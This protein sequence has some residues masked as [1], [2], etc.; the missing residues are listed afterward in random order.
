MKTTFICHIILIMLITPIFAQKNIVFLVGERFHSTSQTMPALAISLEEQ[1]KHKTYYI[2]IPKNGPAENIQLIEKADLLVCYLHLRNL[3]KEQLSLINKYLDS[4]KPLIAFNSTS[5]AF[6]SQPEWFA[7]NFGGA[8][9]GKVK[10]SNQST[11]TVIPE[12][13]KHPICRD[14]PSLKFKTTSP[15]TIPGPLSIGATPLLMGKSGISPAFPVAW[16]FIPKKGN[17]IFYTSLGTAE[18][19]K[20]PSFTKLIQ[21]AV[22]WT[23]SDHK[24]S[25]TTFTTYPPPPKMEPPEKAIILFDG[26]D[27]SQ[28]RHWDLLQHPNSIKIDEQIQKFSNIDLKTKPKW[29]VRNNSIV[30]E[31]GKG[32]LISKKAFGNYLLNVDFLMPEE[33]DYIED[34]TRGSGGVFISGRYEIRIN[35][36]NYRSHTGPNSIYSLRSADFESEM[37][38]GIWHNMKIRYIHLDKGPAL[39]SVDIN[40]KRM[41]GNIR[42]QKT[43]PYG[44]LEPISRENANDLSLHT[45]DKAF[46]DEKM[47]MGENEYT[48]ATRFKTT[49]QTGTVFARTSEVTGWE[50]DGKAFFIGNGTL[51]YDIGWKGIISTN[52]Q[53]SDGKWHHVVLTNTKDMCIMY[54]DGEVAFMKKKFNSPDPDGHVFKIG[55]GFKNFYRSFGGEISNVRY[56][57]KALS[58]QE[59]M[60]LSERNTA[61]IKPIFDWKPEKKVN[62]NVESNEKNIILK[63]PIRL[64]GDFSRIRYANIWLKE[65]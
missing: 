56:F 53:V 35:T 26:K 42:L 63:G 14:L 39:V 45:V 2:N 46:T 19:F 52:R 62:V 58:Y 34:D 20:K 41:H 31:L 60:Q 9:R 28:W 57:N 4:G 23:L 29:S 11:V 44:I 33:P 16:T 54:V 51:Y 65:Y 43:T 64:H 30:T 32:D 8:Y 50:K 37:K 15:T 17:K 21:N 10:D 27:L 13:M 48:V 25:E 36:G 7:L 1:F 49:S 47:K 59:V 61:P 18:D 24:P 55:Y 12:Q 22:Q 40:G 3:P 5:Q 6:E 38:A